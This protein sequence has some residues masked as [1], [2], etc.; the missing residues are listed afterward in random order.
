MELFIEKMYVRKTYRALFSYLYHMIYVYVY[1][2]L[3]IEYDIV[4][5]LSSFG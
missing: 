2:I 5:F 4:I 3:Y 1:D